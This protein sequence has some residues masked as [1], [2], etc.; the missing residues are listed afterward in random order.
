MQD[1]YTTAAQYGLQWQWPLWMAELH[2]QAGDEQR[3]HHQVND[4]DQF[5]GK[6]EMGDEQEIADEDHNDAVAVRL[7][8]GELESGHGYEQ[9]DPCL[10]AV[11]TA[12]GCEYPGKHHESQ[13]C[14]YPG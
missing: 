14:S 12:I 6:Q 10:L 3:C 2:Q 1:H 5:L 4:H 11:D 13:D 7:H 8:L 9:G